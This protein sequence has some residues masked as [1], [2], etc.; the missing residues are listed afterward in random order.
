[1]SKDF[2][3]ILWVSKTATQDEIKKAYRKLAMKYHPDRNKGDKQAEEKFK[4]IWQAYDVLWD[5]KKRKNYDMFGS[6]WASGNPFGWWNY[7]YSTNWFS[8]FEDIFSNFWWA[9]RSSKSSGFEFN[10]EDLF[11]GFW[12][13]KSQTYQKQEPKE[14]SL[15]FE[16]TYEVPI[17]D[18]ILGCHIEVTWYNGE[19]AKLKIPESTKPGTKFR[20]KEFWK[21]SN[22]KT[23]NLLV[24]VDALM[25]K[26]I[27]DVDKK[28]M[29]NLRDNVT[30]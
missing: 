8:W 21:K 14:E 10:I 15:D 13:K 25:P 19:K 20:V 2:Y 5:E 26:N 1:M 22:W 17:F 18:L 11:W 3:S 30:Y 28:L 24:K 6:A 9:W 23:W 27:S 16:K 12:G 7:S 4:E 29:E